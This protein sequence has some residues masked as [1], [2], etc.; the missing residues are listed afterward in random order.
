[1]SWLCVCST[2]DSSKDVSEEFSSMFYTGGATYTRWGRTVCPAGARVV[3]RGKNYCK[4]LRS[5]LTLTTH[6]TGNTFR[7][8]NLGWNFVIQNIAFR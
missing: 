4:V 1:M 3:Y 8:N 5:F 7:I 6:I 2:A